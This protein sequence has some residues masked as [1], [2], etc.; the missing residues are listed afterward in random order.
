MEDAPDECRHWTGSGMT[1]AGVAHHFA[2]NGVF[3][4]RERERGEGSE[5]YLVEVGGGRRERLVTKTERGIL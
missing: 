5:F 1:A 4:G 3:L 2:T